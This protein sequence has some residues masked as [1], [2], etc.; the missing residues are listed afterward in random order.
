MNCGMLTFH[1]RSTAHSPS[2]MH[3]V[4]WTATHRN[5]SDPVRSSAE[6]NPA[7]TTSAPVSNADRPPELTPSSFFLISFL[8]I[9]ISSLSAVLTL[10]R[11]PELGRGSPRR[12]RN[13]A[14]S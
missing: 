2:S 1:G 5:R 4:A 12:A 3:S 10:V 6:T 9:F 8:S 7:D 13:P 14:A 11:S